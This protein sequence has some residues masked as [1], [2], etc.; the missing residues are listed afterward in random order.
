M[1][2]LNEGLMSGHAAAHFNV[3]SPLSVEF[4]GQ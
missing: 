2:N 1:K 4:L 3:R